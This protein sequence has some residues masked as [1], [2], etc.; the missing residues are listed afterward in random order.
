M[1][2][3]KIRGQGLGDGSWGGF[4]SGEILGRQAENF[5][6]DLAGFSV[7]AFVGHRAERGGVEVDFDHVGPPRLGHVG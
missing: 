5:R 4:R 2:N 1:E 3:L 7:M 6:E